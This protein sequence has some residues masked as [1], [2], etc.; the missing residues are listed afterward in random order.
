MR[1]VVMAD[2]FCA[3]RALLAVAP[4]SRAY[5]AGA[6]VRN[7]C[8]ADR[9]RESTGVRHAQFGDGTLAGAARGAGMSAEPPTCTPDFA[10]ALI[11]VLQELVEHGSHH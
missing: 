7:A 3:G 9:F 4:E 1:P 11:L 10:K 8:V 5:M 2:L 6:L